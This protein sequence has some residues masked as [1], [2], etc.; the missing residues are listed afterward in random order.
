[1]DYDDEYYYPQSQGMGA[2]KIFALVV[3]GI[4][5]IICVILFINAFMCFIPFGRKYLC[6]SCPSGM[7]GP[8]CD[9]NICDRGEM[10]DGKCVCDAG[11]TG[12]TCRMQKSLGA[13]VESDTIQD[14][15]GFCFSK[16]GGCPCANAFCTPFASGT[17]SGSTDYYIRSSPDKKYTSYSDVYKNDIESVCIGKDAEGEYIATDGQTRQIPFTYI[18]GGGS[19]AECEALLKDFGCSV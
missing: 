8:D 4:L 13:C 11:F 6:R 12:K 19:K 3:L 1:M 14:G 9:I 17:D 16:K 5:L 10:K 15:A 2:G 7:G 18:Y